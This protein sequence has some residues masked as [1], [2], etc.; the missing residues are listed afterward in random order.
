MTQTVSNAVAVR[1]AGEEII[2]RYEPDFA[3]VLPSFIDPKTFVRLSQGVLRRNPDLERAAAQNV[4]SFLAAL[5]ECARLGHEPGTDRFALTHFNNRKTGVPEIVGIEQYQGEIDRMYRAGAVTAVVCHVVREND[6]YEFDRDRMRRPIHRPAWFATDPPGQL[7]HARFADDKARG[8]MVGAYAYA[9]LPGGGVSDVAEMGRGEIMKHKA[10]AKSTKF[11]E[12]PWEPAMW[13]KTLVHELEKYVPTSVEY[14]QE[15]ARAQAAVEDVTARAVPP[16]P[17]M[18]ALPS[19]P[20]QADVVTGEIMP[21]EPARGPNLPKLHAVLGDLGVSER[22]EKLRVVGAVLGHGVESTND[23]TGA[24]SERVID[25]LT[26][27][28]DSPFP[29]EALRDILAAAEGGKG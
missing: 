18:A 9:E 14:R 15:A 19:F 7:R 20:S 2:A 25:Q 23:L 29:A 27:V 13:R 11:W 22:A 24:E 12:G 26:E 28:R 8:A 16:Q 17:P 6:L 1:S 10:V 3:Q 21:D 5:L 4:G